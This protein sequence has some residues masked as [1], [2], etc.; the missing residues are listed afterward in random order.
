MKYFPKSDK[1][2]TGSNL[3]IYFFI[4]IYLFILFILFFFY[5][6]I[7]FILFIVCVFLFFCFFCVCVCFFHLLLRFLIYFHIYFLFFFFFK[8]CSLSLR[9][10]KTFNTISCLSIPVEGFFFI[11]LLFSSFFFQI[12]SRQDS[13]PR[14]GILKL[15]YLR[16][17]EPL[18]YFETHY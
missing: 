1:N 4:F 15:K 8:E 18:N 16:L 5:L 7:Y 12:Y 14:T 9:I 2:I 6:F 11:L 10:F 3:A 13:Q 17:I